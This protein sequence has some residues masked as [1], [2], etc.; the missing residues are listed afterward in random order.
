MVNMLWCNDKSAACYF[1]LGATLQLKACFRKACLEIS[2]NRHIRK[3]GFLLPAVCFWWIARNNCNNRR[4]R[5][6]S[7][8]ESR[9]S[10]IVGTGRYGWLCQYPWNSSKGCQYNSTINPLTLWLIHTNVSNVCVLITT[11]YPPLKPTI[12]KMDAAYYYWAI[13]R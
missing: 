13:S 12:Y 4:N 6:R 9:W 8:L 7:M 2:S 10:I 11:A 3:I 1:V 5:G